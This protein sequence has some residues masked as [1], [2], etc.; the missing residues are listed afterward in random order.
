[1]SVA[2]RI[3]MIERIVKLRALCNCLRA[4]GGKKS[5]IARYESRLRRLENVL[6]STKQMRGGSVERQ[7]KVIF[8]GPVP[9]TPKTISER[10]LKPAPDHEV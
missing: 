6:A 2:E 3:S 5:I 4:A 8:F 1:M 7:A 10:S 9:G